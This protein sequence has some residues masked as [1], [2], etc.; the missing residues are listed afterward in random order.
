MTLMVE[1]L[2][3]RQLEILKLLNAG[4]SNQEIAQAL[5]ISPLTVKRHASNIYTKLGVSGR[6]KAVTKAKTLGILSTD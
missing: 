4:Q 1:P 3:K 2:T 6:L 5:V